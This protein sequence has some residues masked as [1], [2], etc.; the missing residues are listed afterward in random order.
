M[1]IKK[2]EYL[3]F[4]SKFG[5]NARQVASLAKFVKDKTIK[6][7]LTLIKRHTDRLMSATSKNEMDFLSGGLSV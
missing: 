4:C 3:A 5:L 2:D 1:K 6:R 7:E